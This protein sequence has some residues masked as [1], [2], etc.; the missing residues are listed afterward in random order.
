MKEVKN[1]VPDENVDK[2]VGVYS[3]PKSGNT[4]V[5]QILSGALGGHPPH[6]TVPDIYTHSIW[7]NPVD[8]AGRKT[9]LYKSHSKHDVRNAYGRK[10]T[11]DLVIYIVRHPLDVFCSQLNYISG[12]LTSDKNIM[13]PCNSVESVVSSG[14]IDLFFSCFCVYGTLTPGFADAGSWF[15]NTSMWLQR[16]HESPA[17]VILLR[18]EDLFEDIRALEGAFERIGL[19]KEEL[20]KGLEFS[21]K[22]TKKDGKFYWRKSTG[23]YKELLPR[24]LIQRFYELHRN[25]LDKLGYSL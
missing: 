10:F 3:F 18:Y 1:M 14:N 20:S 6:V 25:P 9:I 15:D 2:I 4:W 5:R 22:N 21:Q 16:M 11:N 23:T 7:E 19:T 13:I 24:E 17:K 8:I 12:N